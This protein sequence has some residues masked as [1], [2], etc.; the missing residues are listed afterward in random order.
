VLASQHRLQIALV[1]ALAAAAAI[2]GDNVGNVGLSATGT[3]VVLGVAGLA[4]HGVDEPVGIW[5]G[6]R[7]HAVPTSI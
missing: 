6:P 5:I 4:S 2:M 3:I 7:S 1:I